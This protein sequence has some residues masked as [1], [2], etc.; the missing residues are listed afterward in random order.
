MIILY[1][2][3]FYLLL[4]YSIWFQ[5]QLIFFSA[6][7]ASAR[8][9]W[10][11]SW[12]P[13]LPWTSSTRKDWDTSQAPTDTLLPAATPWAVFIFSCCFHRRFH[14]I[15]IAQSI[16]SYSLLPEITS[17]SSWTTYFLLNSSAWG[18]CENK[19]RHQRVFF[20]S[21]WISY[22]RSNE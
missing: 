10:I 11:G 9:R 20:L 2:N 21:T 8:C 1:T 7:A 16:T 3:N 18:I 22:L 13:R 5:C 4:Q 12:A 19:L 6:A 14:E 15:V 17:K